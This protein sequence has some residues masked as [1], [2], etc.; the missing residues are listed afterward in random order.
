MSFYA[1]I[2]CKPDGTPFYVGKGKLA[3][4][5]RVSR[6]HNKGHEAVLAEV[7]VQNV[8]IGKLEC[9]S[10]S[11]AYDLERG[12]IK[13]LGIMNV[14]VVNLTHG[15]GGCSGFK[16]P[17]SAKEKISKALSGREFSDSHVA[18][19]TKALRGRKLPPLKEGHKRKISEANS[20]TKIGNKYTLGLVWATDGTSNKMVDRKLP[21]EG[22]WR[23]GITRKTKK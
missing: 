13:R 17:D 9:S 18:N 4:V 6:P 7:G 19:L 8:L 3:R 10:E 5:K 14:D 2:H 21:L 23:L 11:I 15:G 22:G 1:Y 20:K 12:L 16:M